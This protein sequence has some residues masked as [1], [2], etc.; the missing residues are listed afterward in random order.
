MYLIGVEVETKRKEIYRSENEDFQ[1]SPD[2]GAVSCLYCVC[3]PNDSGLQEVH[4]IL[5]RGDRG[6]QEYSRS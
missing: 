5:Q 1:K 2:A 3:L 4:N 6:N